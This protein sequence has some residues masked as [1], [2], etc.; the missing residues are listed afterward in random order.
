VHND[1]VGSQRVLVHVWGLYNAWVVPTVQSG[2]GQAKY[3][4]CSIHKCGRH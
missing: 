4:R 2:A 1:K 3:V